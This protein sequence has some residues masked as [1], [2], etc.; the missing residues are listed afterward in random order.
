[1]SRALLGS[2]AGASGRAGTRRP[3]AGSSEDRA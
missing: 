3:A 1:M 2:V